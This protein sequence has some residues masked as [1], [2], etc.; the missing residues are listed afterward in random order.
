VSA[1]RTAPLGADRTAPLGADRT[2]P[3]GALRRN[4]AHAVCI[5]RFAIGMVSVFSLVVG[6]AALLLATAPAVAGFD[7]VV[8]TSGSMRPHVRPGDVLLVSPGAARSPA[9]GQ[10]IQFRDPSRATTLTHRI[11]RVDDAG[12][13]ITKGDANPSVDSSPVRPDDV[14][15]RAVLLVP[16]VGVPRLWVDDRDW[17]ALVTLT[18]LVVLAGWATRFALRSEYDPWVAREESAGRSR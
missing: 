10:I 16:F 7:P 17:A 15:G 18:V 4:A 11:V 2:A 13:I 9:A 8:I 1:A 12:S 3:L 14:A 6:A 5:G